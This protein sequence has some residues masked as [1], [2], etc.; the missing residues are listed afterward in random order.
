MEAFDAW[1]AADQKAKRQ[2]VD[3]LN[4]LLPAMAH[5]SSVRNWRDVRLDTQ[6]M[7]PPG[8]PR[9]GYSGCFVPAVDVREFQRSM[10]SRQ[11]FVLQE[12]RSAH[13]LE[14]GR[15]AVLPELAVRGSSEERL[16]VLQQES[17]RLGSIV[18]SV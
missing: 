10:K 18:V 11:G 6:E 9:D 7:Q 3:G 4:V 17:L 1:R 14:A 2:R 15:K 16:R 8:S 12:Q 13:D 5:C